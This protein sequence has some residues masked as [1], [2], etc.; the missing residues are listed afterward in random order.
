MLQNIRISEAG[1]KKNCTSLS[2]VRRGLFLDF[3]A[4]EEKLMTQRNGEGGRM[5]ATR[6]LKQLVC[7]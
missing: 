7:F 4:K 5:V 3:E 6:N 1:A 2:L